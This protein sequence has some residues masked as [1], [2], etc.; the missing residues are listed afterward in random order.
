VR[1]P[2]VEHGFVNGVG[3]FIGEDTGRKHG[4]TTYHGN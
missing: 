2:V 1:G 3:G 4:D